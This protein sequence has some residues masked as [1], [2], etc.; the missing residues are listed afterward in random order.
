MWRTRSTDG[1]K[2]WDPPERF[3]PFGVLPRLLTLKNG[4]TVLSFGRPGA[5]LLF[6]RDAKRGKWEGLTTL[7]AE[8]FAGTGI[9]SEDYGFQK[10]KDGQGKPKQTRTSGYTDL[11]PAGPDT[12]LVAYDQF[13]YPNDKGQ[14]RKTILVRKVVVRIRH[15]G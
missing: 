6:S 13:D 5:H 12:F 14:P 7:V 2:T 8:S 10:S 4:V 1:G 11:A 9:R 15:G 3:W